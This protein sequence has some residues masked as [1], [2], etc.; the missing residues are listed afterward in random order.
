MTVEE[1]WQAVT[2]KYIPPPPILVPSVDQDY[3]QQEPFEMTSH[4]EDKQPD[5]T[6]VGNTFEN[7]SEGDGA[8]D[9]F[10][11]CLESQE[12][13]PLITYEDL[14]TEEDTSNRAVPYFEKT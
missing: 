1:Y 2:N 9:S 11:G 13:E 7:Y 12:S 3:V 14:L 4:E 5:S 10:L 8:V 6:F